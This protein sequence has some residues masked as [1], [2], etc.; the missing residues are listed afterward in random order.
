MQRSDYVGVFDD[1][2]SKEDHLRVFEHLNKCNW[3]IF[4]PS[5]DVD[6]HFTSVFLNNLMYIPEEY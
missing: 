5:S 2:L 1:V 4:R 6:L 3:Q